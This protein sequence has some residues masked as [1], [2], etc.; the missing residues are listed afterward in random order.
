M[1]DLSCTVAGIKSINPFWLAS[2]P[3]TDKYINVVRAF[4]AGWGGVVW[5]TL[6][7]DPPVINVSSR[8][9]VHK[10]NN[11]IIGIN[12]IE[13][14]SDRPLQVNLDEIKR[15][16]KE[17]P[18]RVIIGSMM[19]VIE[20]SAWKELAVKI[21]DA[22]VHGI[23]LNL[24]CPHGMCERGMGSAIG[25]VPEMVEKVTRWVKEVVDI[26]VLVKLTPNITNIL[27]AAEAAQAGGGDAVALIN[28]VN[29]I[30]SVDLDAMAPTPVVGSQG[31]HGGYCGTAVKPIALNMVAEIS[32]NN[33]TKDLQ[34]SAIGGIEN[35][36]DAAE[37]IA[38]GADG[39]QVC[40]AAMLYG[41]RIVD[42][43]IAGLS[44]WM[45]DKGY[46]SLDDFRGQA[47]GNTVDWNALD[48]NFDT[49][50]L[51]DTESCIE[52]GRCHIAC[53]D[54]SHQAIAFDVAEDGKRTFTVIDDECVGCNLCQHVCPV[55]D[56]IDMV[57]VDNGLPEMTWPEHPLNPMNS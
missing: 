42:D 26:P 11:E 10:N 24:G 46:Q 57:P 33:D 55:P 21:A 51:I 2:A 32:R 31:T 34:I 43:M 9:G 38:L 14:I 48:M 16:R 54:T 23:E 6:G 41:F 22:G 19:A 35:W 29:S 5:K 53:E 28:T 30:V 40:T 13:L 39:L 47:V 20:E 25:Q 36:R 56:C 52:C 37:F 49:K 7:V 50:A 8:Y 44:Q 15:V 3:P 27:W 18:D 4:E 17:W 1:A 12:N 45:D